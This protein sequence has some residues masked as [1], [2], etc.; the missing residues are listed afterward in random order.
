M[1]FF[2]L[3]VFV[4]MSSTLF[5]DNPFEYS[6]YFSKTKSH[7]WKEMGF[8]LW[9]ENEGEDLFAG[10][11]PLQERKMKWHK[12]FLNSLEAVISICKI[13]LD[14]P[15]R[16]ITTGDRS[17]VKAIMNKASCLCK[18]LEKVPHDVSQWWTQRELGKYKEREKLIMAKDSLSQVEWTSARN[19][20]TR[21]R[22]WE[23]DALGEGDS[24]HDDSDYSKESPSKKNRKNINDTSTT[25]PPYQILYESTPRS[26]YSPVYDESSSSDLEILPKNLT[27]AFRAVSN[28]SEDHLNMTTDDTSPEDHLDMTTDT[29]PEDHLDMT[30]ASNTSLAL[31]KEAGNKKRKIKKYIARD[32]VKEILDAYQIRI[33]AGEKLIYNGV[34][35]LDFIH[36]TNVIEKGPL[37]IGVI[38]IYNTDCTKY[39]PDEFKNYISDQIQDLEIKAV[40]FADGKCIDKLYVNCEEEVLQFL[41][42]FE[43]VEDLESLGK[44]LDE[45]SISYSTASNDL[46]YIQN[47]LHHFYFLYK[48]DILLQPMSEY[49]FNAYVWTPL[50]KNAF[51]GKA[52]IKLNYGEL[53][54][55]SYNRLKE[56]LNIAGNSAPKLDGK[57][58][59]K[60]L[61]TEILA[62]EDGVLNTHGKRTGDLKKLEYCMKVILTVLYF[63]LPS[64]S[65]SKISEIET[66]SLQSNGFRLTI[67]ASKYLFENTI[68]TMDLQDIDVPKTVEG[69]STLIKAIKIV[70][71]WKSRTRK[72]TNLFY[73]IIKKGHGRLKNGVLFTPKK[74][75]G[76]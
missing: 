25:S 32:I 45:N 35:V 33:L 68:V 51:L 76:L 65:K 14:D 20:K 1:E 67:S 63:A 24:K 15:A 6:E 5:S 12:Q 11:K 43:H 37:S 10:S 75:T 59:L 39:L 42:K 7:E 21:K 74:F 22:F 17:Y 60:S 50:L 62:Q 16:T 28:N 56:I 46:I 8:I 18:Y 19:V 38:N 71:S 9:L 27:D 41:D 66:Y 70:L 57:G 55:K 61:G 36:S 26:K 29:S 23:V 52:D 58:F 4:K 13:F 73:E 69:F 53:A 3:L 64:A 31:I 40:E 49:E 72:N 47:L 2:S 48:N 30:T 44:S 34:N 54:S